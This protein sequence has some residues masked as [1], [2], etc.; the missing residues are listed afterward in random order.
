MLAVNVKS[1]GIRWPGFGAGAGIE[2]YQLMTDRKNCLMVP[3]FEFSI[4]VALLPFKEKAP[5]NKRLNL[6]VFTN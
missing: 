2:T 1:L 6:L 4:G 3:L 5:H